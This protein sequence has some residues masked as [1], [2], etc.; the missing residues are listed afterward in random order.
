MGNVPLPSPTKETAS[1]AVC[2]IITRR[3]T[4]SLQLIPPT[5]KCVDKLSLLGRTDDD[6]M[7]KILLLEDR[8]V[9]H[10]VLE[11]VLHAQ[12]TKN[13]VVQTPVGQR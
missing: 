7:N 10:V 4:G 1:K 8:Y 2:H 11:Q 13:E 12:R 3:T 9:H 6:V 5:D